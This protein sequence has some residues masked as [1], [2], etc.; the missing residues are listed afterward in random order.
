MIQR[1]AGLAAG[2]ITLTAAACSPME[3][4]AGKGLDDSQLGVIVFYS[5][6][7]VL[8]APDTVRAGVPFE[9]GVRTYGNDCVTKDRTEVRT[10]GQRV[11][12][13]PYDYRRTAIA[14]QDI[15]RVF[16]HEA[17]V[18]LDQPGVRQIQFRGRTLPA[19][20]VVTLVRSLV[21]R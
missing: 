19:D 2:V 14:C 9:V 4:P 17:V 15:L 16:D 12:I 3:P 11:Q 13:R 20:T 5:D 7:I 1:I 21:V 8:N 18:T 10:E 6:P